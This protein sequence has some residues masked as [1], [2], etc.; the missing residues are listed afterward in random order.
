MFSKCCFAK[1]RGSSQKLLNDFEIAAGCGFTK[2]GCL[3]FRFAA[4]RLF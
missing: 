2:S 3:F 1:N 4:V